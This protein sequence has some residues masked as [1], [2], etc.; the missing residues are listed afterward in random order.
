MVYFSE[1]TFFFFFGVSPHPVILFWL[2]CLVLSFQ[3]EQAKVHIHASSVVII[4][5]SSSVYEEL[6]EE[7]SSLFGLGT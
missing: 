5:S 6:K 2:F 7:L 4:G 1:K 3:H